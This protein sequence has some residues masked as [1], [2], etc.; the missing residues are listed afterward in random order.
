MADGRTVSLSCVATGRFRWTD[1]QCCAGRGW[2]T[3][4]HYERVPAQCSALL[5]KYTKRPHVR[6]SC[7]CKVSPAS[8]CYY[9]SQKS[10]SS[11]C[12]SSCDC[13]TDCSEKMTFSEPVSERL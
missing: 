10:R 4:S 9:D 8:E 1:W 13:D 2:Q 11:T 6:D 5:K 3:L 12:V 7:S